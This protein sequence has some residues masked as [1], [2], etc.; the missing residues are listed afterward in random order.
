MSINLVNSFQKFAGGGFIEAT[1][2]TITTDG[3]F[4]VHTF[5]SSADFEITAGSGDV[6]YLII[7]GGGGSMENWGISGGAGAG[8]IEFMMQNKIIKP[9]LNL[10]LPDRFVPQGTQDELHEEL[11]L[12]AKGI[13]KS[14]N[15][16]LAK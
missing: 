14:I 3:N 2:G 12:D 1:G 16:Y 4:K 5:N 8:V 15:D 13:E 7:A 9:V 6:T 11:G 10:G